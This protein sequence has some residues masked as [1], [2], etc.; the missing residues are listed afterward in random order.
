MLGMID[1]RTQL[2]TFLDSVRDVNLNYDKSQLLLNNEQQYV[3][4][5]DI[6]SYIYLCRCNGHKS[7]PGRKHVYTEN[8][9][10]FVPEEL[11]LKYY[12]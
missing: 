8:P 11:W 2:E 12:C 3:L 10:N 9:N 6:L 7:T 1:F 5:I 4:E